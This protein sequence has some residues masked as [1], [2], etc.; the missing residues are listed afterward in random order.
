MSVSQD[1]KNLAILLWIGTLF[2]GFIPG[3]I[4]FLLK[5]DD[6]YVKEQSKEALNWVITT[7]IA[8]MAAGLLVIIIIGAF[9]LPAIFVCHVVFCIMGVIAVNKGDS[10][11]VPFAIRLLK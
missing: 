1:S 3:L 7:V 4:L 6:A 11:R 8:Y 9:L 2:F 5:D 10:F